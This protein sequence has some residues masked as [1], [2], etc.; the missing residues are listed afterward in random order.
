MREFRLSGSVEGVMSNHDPYSDLV[1]ASRPPPGRPRRRLA[2]FKEADRARC[3]STGTQLSGV[4]I[5]YAL[6]K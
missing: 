4:R 5:E 1:S 3:K 2:V 6:K